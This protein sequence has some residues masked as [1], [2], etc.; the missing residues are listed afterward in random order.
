MQ[1]NNTL[2]LEALDMLKAMADGDDFESQCTLAYIYYEGEGVNKDFDISL[3]WSNKIIMHKECDE[4]VLFNVTYRMGII[5]CEKEEYEDA[6]SKFTFIFESKTSSQDSKDNCALR[7][8]HITKVTDVPKAIILYENLVTR[9]NPPVVKEVLADACNI[10]GGLYLY[11]K[12]LDKSIIIYNKSVELMGINETFPIIL[13]NLGYAY[14]MH[15]LYEE[16]HKYYLLASEKD[17]LF[18]HLNLANLYDKGYGV[19]MDLDKACL[20]FEKGGDKLM[21]WNMAREQF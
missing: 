9:S 1:D 6:L 18:A 15:G 17:Y 11:K 14:E 16:A 5:H 8:A 3:Y 19:E 7:I 20:Y 12:E 13:N 21:E 10:L 2:N 4:E